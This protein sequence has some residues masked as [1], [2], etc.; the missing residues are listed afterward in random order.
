MRRTTVGTTVRTFDV[1][2]Q[3]HVDGWSFSLTGNGADDALFTIVNSSLNVAAN[4]VPPGP[5]TVNVLMSKVGEPSVITNVPFVIQD[6]GVQMDSTKDLTI[7]GSFLPN[8]TANSEIHLMFYPDA[9]TEMLF[10][11]SSLNVGYG[12]VGANTS[13]DVSAYSLN[14]ASAADLL[15]TVASVIVP[16]QW[17]NLT[18]TNNGSNQTLFKVNGVSIHQAA[19]NKLRN[20]GTDVLSVI[21]VVTPSKNVVVS[22]FKVKINNV[23]YLA[24][25]LETVAGSLATSGGPTF[26]VLK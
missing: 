24:E 20:Q 19:T 3:N 15:N 5:K 12:A 1:D 2:G 11:V 6:R 10:M 13:G 26:N 17:N 21:K 14:G 9:G 18:I 16:N 23:Y 8:W 4:Y 22:N 25:E 7:P